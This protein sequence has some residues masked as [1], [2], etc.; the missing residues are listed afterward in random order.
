MNGGSAYMK[1]I[2]ENMF[3]SEKIANKGHPVKDYQETSPP[4]RCLLVD[5][6]EKMRQN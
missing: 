1:Y 3:Y 2:Y 4:D 6:R 5:K